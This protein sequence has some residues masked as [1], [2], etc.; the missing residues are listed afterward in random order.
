MNK[1]TLINTQITVLQYVHFAIHLLNEPI[2]E[3]KRLAEVATYVS[4]ADIG[5]DMSRRG[6]DAPSDKPS[7]RLRGPSG[8]E[9]PNEDPA[10]RGI[11][12][13]DEYSAWIHAVVIN[14]H[15]CMDVSLLS[16]TFLRAWGSDG[17]ITAVKTLPRDIYQPHTHKH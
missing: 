17:T 4:V 10:Q 3:G 12:S 1:N 6:K 15:I 2:A 11:R 8:T 16:D 7:R 5:G 14:S 9:A 13:H